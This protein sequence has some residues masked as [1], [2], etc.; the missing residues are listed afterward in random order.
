MKKHTS[1]FTLVELMVTIAVMAIM[2]AIAF[3]S[4]RDFVAGARIANRSEQIANLFR[5]AKSE[6]VR[7]G[8]PVIIC[9]TQIRDDGRSLGTCD[10]SK[11]NSGL[12]AYADNNRN[13]VFDAASDT[14][15]RTITVNAGSRTNVQV[16]TATYQL[17]LTGRISAIAP[18]VP[19]FIFM[20]S[21]AFGTKPNAANL[22]GLQ[23]Q[24]RFAAFQLYNN[25]AYSAG[26]NFMGRIVYITPTGVVNTC[27]DQTTR[28]NPTSRN[29]TQNTIIAGVCQLPTT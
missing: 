3:P 26:R 2:A 9:G 20:P 29:A 7:L 11:Y 10:A 22:T 6:A 24:N 18:T 16:G 8:K 17:G 27:R 14:E 23:I 4:M 13:G 1:G 5:F 15:L 25:V 19:E 28:P 21:G 12:M